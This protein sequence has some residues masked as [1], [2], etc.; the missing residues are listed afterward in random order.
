MRLICGAGTLKDLAGM[1]HRKELFSFLES[2]E[3]GPD[4]VGVGHGEREAEL[5][6]GSGG[7]PQW[8]KFCL[9][10]QSEG[11]GGK[12]H[13]EF[14][15]PHKASWLR[16]SIRC[17]NIIDIHISVTQEVPDRENTFLIKIDVPSEHILET[18][19]ALHVKA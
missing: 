9:L 1:V 14:F 15:I 6:S 12:C 16:F 8:Q 3:A 18:T 11:G 19:D 7:K 13:L 17:S 2:E 10:L 5:N 4:P